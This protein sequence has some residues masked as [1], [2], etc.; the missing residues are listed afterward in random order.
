MERQPAGESGPRSD[1]DAHTLAM[2][3]PIADIVRELL[4]LLDA[5][6]VAVIGGVQETRAVN[7][8]MNGREPQRPQVLRFALQLAVMIADVA[9]REFCKAWFHGSNPQLGDR[10]PMIMLR[11]QPLASVQ[12]DLLNAARAFA[13]RPSRAKP[14]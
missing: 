9:D 6:T 8:W 11:D 3:L 7:N 12:T 14:E 4:G 1:I 13:L 2:S 5:T 10:V